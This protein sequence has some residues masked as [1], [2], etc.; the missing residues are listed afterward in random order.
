M[1]MEHR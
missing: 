1:K